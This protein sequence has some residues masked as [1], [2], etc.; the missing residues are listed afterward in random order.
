MRQMKIF[1]FWPMII[2]I[3]FAGMAE[4]SS[5]LFSTTRDY[6]FSNLDKETLGVISQSESVIVGRWGS[7]ACDIR[8]DYSVNNI[9]FIGYQIDYTSRTSGCSE[10]LKKYPLSKEV[11]VYFDSAKPLY[12]ALEKG[13]PGFHI[14]GLYVVLIFSYVFFAWLGV[15]IRG[16]EKNK[17][18]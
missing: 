13:S 4:Y 8:Y 16:S 14:Y 1:Y 18:L 17:I 6:L 5:G 2:T 12:S 7:V 3:M 10:K 15:V 9:N 11:A